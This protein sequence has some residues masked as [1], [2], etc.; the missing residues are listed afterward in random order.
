MKEE[1]ICRCDCH[2]FPLFHHTGECCKNTG[3]IYIN[4]DGTI[5]HEKYTLLNPVKE[6]ICPCCGGTGILKTK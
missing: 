1:N 5:N 3:K 6:E 2:R 4:N